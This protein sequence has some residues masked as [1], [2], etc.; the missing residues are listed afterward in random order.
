M[1]VEFLGSKSANEEHPKIYIRSMLL[2]I[3]LIVSSIIWTLELSYMEMM[4]RNDCKIVRSCEW[5][6]LSN[7]E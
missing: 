1:T 5:I 3:E 6:V 2:I 7:T 4:S